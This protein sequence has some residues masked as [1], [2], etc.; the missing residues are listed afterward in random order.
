MTRAGA[1]AGLPVTS[2]PSGTACPTTAISGTK[3]IASANS[4]ATTIELRPVRAPSATPAPLSTYV[5][6]LD[7][8]DAPP[9][10]AAP[11]PPPH[12]RRP[13][14]RA[15]RPPE[16]PPPGAPRERA[17]GVRQQAGL[18]AHPAA[19]PDRDR[20]ADRVEEV[21]HEQGEDHRDQRDRQRVLEVVG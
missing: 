16:R 2:P 15:G 19:A 21:G 11:D 13:A 6:T 4:A 17:R 20:R 1:I 9:S 18:V 3:K 8:P 14:R 7:V 12:A 5:V 10:A